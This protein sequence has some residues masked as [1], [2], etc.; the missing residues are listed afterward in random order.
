MFPFMS[1]RIAYGRR[2]QDE[3]AGLITTYGA[4]AGQEAE[5]RARAAG[6]TQADEAFRR[7]VAERV[8]R[9]LCQAG[10]DVAA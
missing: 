7:L 3:A 6:L 9:M 5:A 4:A 8:A 1:E 10:S 2:I